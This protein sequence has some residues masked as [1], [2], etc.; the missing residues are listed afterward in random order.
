MRNILKN[1]KGLTLVEIIIAIAV[2]AIATSI[3]VTS[4][5]NVLEDQRIDSDLSKLGQ[6][7]T[8]LKQVL[9]YDDAFNEIQKNEAVY[10]DNK[11]KIVCPVEMEDDSVKA[12]VDINKITVNDTDEKLKDKCPILH[13]YLLDYIGD[14][15]T[16]SSASFKSGKYEVMVEFNGTRVSDV[17]EYTITNDTMN[18]TNSGSEFLKS[19]K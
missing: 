6:V 9:L 16:L 1:N 18:V 19:E 10:D 12:F 7:D 14:D 17:R 15:I 2:L 13:G 3:L 4:Y 8:T 5:T 11:L